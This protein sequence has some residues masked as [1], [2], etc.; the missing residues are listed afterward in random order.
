MILCRLDTSTQ[1]KEACL[2]KIL[3]MGHTQ[4][5]PSES[6][7]C[8]M[9]TE[10]ATRLGDGPGILRSRHVLSTLSADTGAS[11]RHAIMSSNGWVVESPSTGRSK[12]GNRAV[13]SA[14]RLET[15]VTGA[16]ELCLSSQRK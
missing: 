15:S 3:L 1:G 2:R 6:I 4:R 7:F 14:S 13:Q 12:S 11:S 9:E 16:W 10:S 8:D 5:S